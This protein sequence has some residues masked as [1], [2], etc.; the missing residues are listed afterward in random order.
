MTLLKDLPDNLFDQFID[1]RELI[2]KI[3]EPCDT[4]IQVTILEL[5]LAELVY[6]NVKDRDERTEI[7]KDIADNILTN[8]STW[9][10]KLAKYKLNE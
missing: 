1:S 6:F 2:L 10:E 5:L 3:I 4:R 7:V 9:D 8:L